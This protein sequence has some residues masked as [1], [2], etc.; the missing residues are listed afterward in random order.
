LLDNI[1]LQSCLNSQELASDK[2]EGPMKTM[3]IDAAN[4]SIV[5]KILG[6]DVNKTTTILN[7]KFH[8]E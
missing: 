2:D 7:R 8:T 5:Y 3:R 4:K 1:L 6:E